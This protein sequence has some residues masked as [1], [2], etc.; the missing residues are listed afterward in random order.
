M[1]PH[2]YLSPHLDDA[3]FSCGGLI[4]VQEARGEPVSVLT[5]FAGDPSDYRITAYAAELHSRWGEAGPPVAIRR[6][7]DR[8]ACGRLGASVLHLPYA[9]AVYRHDPE[10]NPLYPDE[11]SIFANIHPSEDA[12]VDEL[13]AALQETNLTVANVYCPIGLGNHVDHRLTRKAAEQCKVPLMY[14]FECPYAARGDLP[15]QDL[16]EPHGERTIQVLSEEAIASWSYAST[17]Y[18]TQ[19]STFWGS[20]DDLFAEI[21][22]FHDAGGGIQLILPVD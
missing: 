22:A 17:E 21:R 14:Y 10:G 9:D 2:V 7:E 4:A 12:L 11:P 3:V 5:L 6:A 13:A 15:P 19:L 18:R 20:E 16:G 1:K 8:V